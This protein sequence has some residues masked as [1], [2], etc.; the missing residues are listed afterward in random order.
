MVKMKV[1]GHPITFMV[2]T[3]AEYSV[4]TITV[5]LFGNRKAAIMGATG[6]QVEPQL[7][8]QN[9]ICQLGGHQTCHEFLY[10]LECSVPL[11]GRDLLSILGVQITFEPG[12]SVSL[13]L[14]EPKKGLILVVT[15]PRENEKKLH[16]FGQKRTPQ[17][18]LRPGTLPVRQRQH[19]IPR[20][21]QLGIQEHI[22]WLRKEGILV[23]C[24][25][26]WNTPLLPVKKPSGGYLPMQDLRAVNSAAIIL[27]P[28]VTNP[29]TL[30]GQL[31]SETEWFTCLDLKIAFFCLRL[32]S[33]TSH[34]LPSNGKTPKHEER[35]N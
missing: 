23:K 27:H 18:W 35:H 7:F 8:C 34:Y 31:P 32:A 17:E 25:S 16:T 22:S 29:Y 1:G 2:D 9:Q 20:E 10:L 6:S 4:V 11:L 15:L 21:A 3:W 5:A 33:K 12:E 19:L 13:T 24:Q 26:P 14:G 30:L 28:V